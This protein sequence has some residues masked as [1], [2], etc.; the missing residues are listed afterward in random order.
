MSRYA[1]GST[2]ID[3]IGAVIIPPTMKMMTSRKHL[4]DRRA[5]GFYP[6]PFLQIEPSENVDCSA[7]HLPVYRA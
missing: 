4:V 3:R 5:S 1:A 2:S 6:A 7:A